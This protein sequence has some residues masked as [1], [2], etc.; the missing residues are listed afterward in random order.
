MPLR[1]AIIGAGPAGCA[2][3]R[4]LHVKDPSIQTTIF[5]SEGSINFRSQGGTLDLHVKTGQL[6]LREAGLWD[7]FEKHARYDGEAL[8]IADKNCLCYPKMGAG[9][10]KSTSTGRPEIDRPVLREML[11]RS[12]PEGTV[13][14]NKK[15]K[16][17]KRE[18][19][20]LNLHFTD[21]GVE[22]GY[23]L[24]VGADGAW[25]KTR[26]L[27]SDVKPYYSGVAGHVM[28]IS[29]AQ[30]RHPALYAAVNRGSLFSYS[31]GRGVFAQ[32][33]GDGSLSIGTWS[34]HPPDWQQ[35]SDHD[36]HD[37]QAVKKAYRQRYADWNPTLLA[38]T[39]EADDESIHPRDLFMLPVGH[40]WEHVPGITLVGD[41]AHVMTPFAGEGVNLAFADCLD[42]SRA[43]C[44]AAASIIPSPP[45]PNSKN[46]NGCNTTSQ[47][48]AGTP[49]DRGVRAF[50]QDMFARATKYQQLTYDSMNAVFFSPG[51]PRVGIE[52][53][54]LRMAQDELGYWATLLVTPLVYA[55]FFVFKLIW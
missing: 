48:V 49:L 8:Q 51:A 34:V 2:L 29:N 32:Y 55:W 21:G 40:R 3:A 42:L 47:A 41:A 22:H 54:F 33:M 4:L 44:S 20:E 18:G 25:S 53:Y 52:R 27:I 37:P 12:L 16:E 39:Q 45:E 31:E 43:I 28:S 5:E 46:N 14:W 9:H 36:V 50:E 35:S 17:V 24:I 38:F 10:S 19:R 1:I 26:S 13:Q 30:E 6:A 7:E 23:D 15:L 11:Y